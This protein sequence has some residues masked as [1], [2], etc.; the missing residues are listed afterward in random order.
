MSH[1]F[2][3]RGGHLEVSRIG[4][5]LEDLRLHAEGA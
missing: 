5:G 4:V 2:M 3:H 1:H